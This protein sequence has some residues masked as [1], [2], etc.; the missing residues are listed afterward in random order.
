MSKFM[1]KPTV[2][3]TEVSRHGMRTGDFPLPPVPAGSYSVKNMVLRVLPL[4]KNM[5]LCEHTCLH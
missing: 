3:N 5:V 2:D 1:E 4:V